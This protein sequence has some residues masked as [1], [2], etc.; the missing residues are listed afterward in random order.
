MRVPTTVN[1]RP[2]IHFSL[3]NRLIF[4]GQQKLKCCL[5]HLVSHRITRASAISAA[6]RQNLVMLLRGR[7][8]QA[9]A[10][11]NSVLGARTNRNSIMIDVSSAITGLT[12]EFGFLLDAIDGA[13]S[14]FTSTSSGWMHRL[15]ARCRAIGV[16]IVCPSSTAIR[17]PTPSS[18]TWRCN[19]SLRSSRALSRY[20]TDA[21]SSGCQFCLRR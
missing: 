4:R 12:P 16:S 20:R 1:P 7:S 18:R 19:G 17:S 5:T 21:R 3:Q 13:R 6:G 2:G 8:R 14:A 9:V 10:Y 11:A 15:L